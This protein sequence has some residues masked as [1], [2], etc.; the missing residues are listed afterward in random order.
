[1]RK[2]TI[3]ESNINM[4]TIPIKSQIYFVTTGKEKLLGKRLLVLMIGCLLLTQAQAQADKRLVLAD[5]YF[6]S[7]EYFTAAGL[8]G[9]FLSAAV[10]TKAPSDFPLNSKK[11]TEGKTGAYK[12]KTDILFKQAESYRLSNYWKEAA[13]LYK[14]CFEKDVAKY[15]SA[16]YLYALCQRSIGDYAGA[17]ESI[18]RFINEYATGSEF[19]QA[20]MKEKESLQ[21]IK[22]QLSRPDLSMYH[23]EKLNTLSGDGKGIYAPAATAGQLIVTST[24]ADSV[25]LGMNPYHNRLFTTTIANNI[26]QSLQPVMIESLD[27]SLNQGTAS[28][29]PN[30]N[31][32]Y[33]TQWKKENGQVISAIYFSKKTANGWSQP[34]LLTTVNETGHNSKQPFCTPDGKWLFFA[35]DR[36]VGKGNFDIWYASLNSEGTTGDPLN[37]G[38]VNTTENEQAPFYH[39]ASSSLVFSSDRTPGMGGYDLFSAKGSQAIWSKIENMGHPINSSRDDIYFFA[40]GENLLSNALFSSDRGS[41][42]CLAMYT[43]SKTAK[44]RMIT[45]VIRNCEDNEPVADADVILQDGT[46]RTIKAIT[47]ADGKYSFEAIGALSQQQL[48]VSKEKYKDTASL[49]TV[50]STNES[51]WQTDTLYNTALCIEK[52]LVIKVENVVSVYLILTKAN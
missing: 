4:N 40:G 47:S 43:V 49:V 6:A 9:Q 22:A 16:L 12:D 20:A 1:M 14:E 44:K 18:T 31:Y 51:N 42:C 41:E 11:N 37:A 27:A 10:K 23:L 3:K 30:G 8:Y 25:V 34:Q 7:G 28:V 45:G 36:A 38:N 52:K 5:Q 26:L 48:T 39:N 35:S 32:L 21:F 46:G 13:A 2:I 33:F 17:E 19:Q 15:A 50:E 29:H 24:Q